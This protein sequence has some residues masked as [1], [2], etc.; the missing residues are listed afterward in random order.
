MTDA[1]RAERNEEIVRLYGEGVFLRAIAARFCL[2]QRST[3]VT[4]VL[5]RAREA[6]DPRAA[7]RDADPAA[8]AVMSRLGRLK[9]K[10]RRRAVYGR[11]GVSDFEGGCGGIDADFDV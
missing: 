10:I 5:R 11:R 2:A 3:A 8:V 7:L 9:A 4:T 1:E 6:G